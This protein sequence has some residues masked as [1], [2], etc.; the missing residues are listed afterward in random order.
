MDNI[1]TI[2]SYNVDSMRYR[3]LK[4]CYDRFTVCIV[5]YDNA[6][7]TKIKTNPNQEIIRITRTITDPT[8]YHRL[9]DCYQLMNNTNWFSGCENRHQI[10]PIQ[11]IIYKDLA[12]VP[13][14]LNNMAIAERYW[15]SSHGIYL[16]VDEKSPLFLDQNNLRKNYMCL[17]GKNDKPYRKR[18]KIVL[19]YEIG[20]FDDPRRAHEY[21]VD[22]HFDK[23]IAHPDVRMIKHPIWSSWARYKINVNQKIIE[24]FADEIIKH[25]FDNSQIEIDDNWE[26]CYGSATFDLQKFPNPV[27][28]VSHLRR[29]NFRVTLWIHPFV[30]LNCR[31]YYDHA[32][33]MDY[34]VKNTNNVVLT[35]WWQGIK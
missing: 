18:K 34:F 5:S 13:S 8:L 33:R 3:F 23:P 14:G 32:K 21:V 4:N 6:T 1:L 17:V 9:I 28:L 27:G 26:T 19:N 11:T 24:E 22:K 10:W 15:L 20:V 29:K 12:Y 30:N 2:G 35:K 16:Y 7:V 25:G 31:D